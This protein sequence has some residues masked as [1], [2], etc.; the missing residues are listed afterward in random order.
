MTVEHH[1]FLIRIWRE[2]LSN[3]STTGEW[4]GEVEHIQSGRCWTFDSIDKYLALIKVDQQGNE[5][6]E[7]LEDQ[8]ESDSLSFPLKESLGKEEKT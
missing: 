3:L 6:M 5:R 2:A 1:S 8:A 4:Q 7:H